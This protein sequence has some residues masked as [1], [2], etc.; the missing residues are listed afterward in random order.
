MYINRTRSTY[1]ACQ[2]T[3]TLIISVRRIIGV[4]VYYICIVHIILKHI[5]IYVLNVH[6]N[7]INHHD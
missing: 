5:C 6:V 3:S 1:T 7:A 4:Y 2:Y